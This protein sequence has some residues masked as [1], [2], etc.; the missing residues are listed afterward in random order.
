VTQR[1]FV[2]AVTVND[3]AAW[4]PQIGLPVGAVTHA[5]NGVVL[6]QCIQDDF[7]NIMGDCDFEG[8][9]RGASVSAVSTA[10][11]TAQAR[12]SSGVRI[13]LQR[14]RGRWLIAEFRGGP[15]PAAGGCLGPSPGAG[16]GAATE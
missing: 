1:W 8:E 12:L 14:V 15:H 6:T 2:H 7:F 4:C 13:T 9:I 3:R 10:G 5:L 11:H 16:P